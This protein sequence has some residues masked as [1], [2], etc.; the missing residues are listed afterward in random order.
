VGKARSGFADR[1]I[2]ILYGSMNATT[3]ADNGMGD[4][5]RQTTEGV[6]T[7][8]RHNRLMA[9]IA[10]TEAGRTIASFTR[11]KKKK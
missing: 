10:D 5:M 4:L 8:T 3:L 1:S 11:Y 7:E 9:L 6:W 2:F